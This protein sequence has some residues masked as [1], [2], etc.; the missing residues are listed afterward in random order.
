[1]RRM[2]KKIIKSWEAYFEEH[3]D[4]SLSDIEALCEAESD[5]A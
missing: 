5:V 2:T 4:M 3:R 1:M